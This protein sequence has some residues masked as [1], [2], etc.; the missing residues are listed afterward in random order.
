M[1]E[2][3]SSQLTWYPLKEYPMY[4][5]NKEGQIRNAKTGKLRKIDHSSQNCARLSIRTS[6]GKIKCVH[7]DELVAKTFL[8]NKDINKF[9]VLK[10]IDGN[11]FNCSADNLIWDEDDSAKQQY[12]LTH[13]VYKPD[14]YYTFYPL[15]E[16]PNSI[17]EI[18]KLGQI[19][20]KNTGKL[21]KGAIN[22]GYWTYTLIIDGKIVFRFAHIMVAKQ[23]IPNPDNKPI[24]NHIDENK[25]NACIDNLEWVTSSENSNFGDAQNKANI[26]RNKPINEYDLQGTYNR[27]WRSI[28]SI[29]AYFKKIYPKDDIKTSLIH[30]IKFN[31]QNSAIKKPFSNRIFMRY[32]GDCRDVS[33]MVSKNKQRKYNKTVPEDLE[34]PKDYLIDPND[35]NADYIETLQS[36]RRENRSLS[37]NQ[38]QAIDYAVECIRKLNK[39]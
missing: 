21:L 31:S 34:I 36:L 30:T 20:N 6:S 23:F 10:H 14:E 37:Y 27:T 15:L 35:L 38:Q 26:A 22:R 28:T 3:N 5:I 16:F 8:T 9:S 7:V 19:R 11:P 39:L 29:V 17:Y 25:S 33:F 2:T 24:V 4:E 13:G 12:F 18:N 1:I 32:E